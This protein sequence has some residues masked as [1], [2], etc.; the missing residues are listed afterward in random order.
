VATMLDPCATS[1]CNDPIV[2]LLGADP[3]T[4]LRPHFGM[5]LG[6]D[7]FEA[8]D[9][10]PRG[11]LRLHNA[12][13][14]GEGVVWG[15]GVQ[16]D[17]KAREVEVVRGLGTDAAGRELYLAGKVCLSLPMWLGEHPEAAGE[18][19]KDGTR[20]LLA[21]VVI[22]SRP[23]LS[24]QVPALADPCNGSDSAT[25]Y[26]RVEEGVELLMR[27][28][29]A[30]D[31]IYPYHRLRLLFGLDVPATDEN[32]EIAPDDREVLNRLEQVAASATSDRTAALRDAFRDVAGFDVVD[33]QPGL[34]PD[35]EG[36]LLFPAGDDAELVLAEI[37]CNIRG[38]GE[39]LEIADGWAEITDRPSH[40]A[41]TTIQELTVSGAH[42]GLDA[43][44]PRVD[45]QAVTRQGKKITLPATK[46]LHPDSV[47]DDAFS[48]SSF[49]DGGW[50][51]VTITN[52]TYDTAQSAVVV[53]L[54][55]AP[56]GDVLRLIARG[57]GPTPLLG[58]DLVPFAGPT[59]GPPGSVDDGHDFVLM[60]RS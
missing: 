28:G 4:A 40:V 26:S 7:D 25:A 59:G 35:E 42:A 9:A 47:S 14:H 43:G 15:L 18:A 33:R 57:T 17:K 41:T 39:S 32:G 11:K 48:V 49:A 60:M 8:L 45:P 34:Q 54:H 24:R 38:E 2:T 21:H 51:D 44:G 29:P 22:R 31:P 19:D 55:A 52:T 12:W 36:D 58:A 46:P 16:I 53:T 20:P 1:D 50:D 13:L 6:V 27:P 56:T 37:R 5:L 30:P 10:N 3:F 23:C